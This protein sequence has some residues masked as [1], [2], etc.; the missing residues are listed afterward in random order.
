MKDIYYA[1]GVEAAGPCSLEIRDDT[2]E[3][4]LELVF[5]EYI[6]RQRWVWAT[7]FPKTH[8]E[9]WQ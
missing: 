8:K 5:S 3:I 4:V 7:S 6:N 9:S 1:I 2:K